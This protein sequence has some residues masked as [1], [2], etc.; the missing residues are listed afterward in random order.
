[1]GRGLPQIASDEVKTPINETK[2]SSKDVNTTR[3]VTSAKGVSSPRKEES[4]RKVPS[5][6][7]PPPP[8]VS[9]S[10]LVVMATLLVF[11]MIGTSKMRK[12]AGKGLGGTHDGV[13]LTPEELKM[14]TGRRG[15]PIYLA[16][17]GSVFDVSSARKTYGTLLFPSRHLFLHGLCPE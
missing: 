6:P 4:Q 11:G 1:M 7:P 14:Y 13:L 8:Q 2:T 12:H 9:I 16:I 15:S 17:L 5:P 3:V 10:T